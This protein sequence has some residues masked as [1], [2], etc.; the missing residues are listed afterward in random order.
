MAVTEL[1]YDMAKADLY[2]QM[3]EEPPAW[4]A[5]DACKAQSPT[6]RQAAFDEAA[7]RAQVQEAEPGRCPTV[8]VSGAWGSLGPIAPCVSPTT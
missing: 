6:I 2:H 3:A 8:S 7:A 1:A 4:A 5:F